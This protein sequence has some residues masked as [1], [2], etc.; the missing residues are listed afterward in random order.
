MGDES[1][2]FKE[3]L[4]LSTRKSA[5]EEIPKLYH[6]VKSTGKY[7]IIQQYYLACPLE[8]LFLNA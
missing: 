6:L 3:S 5:V 1:G 2:I 8:T 7:C 4:R